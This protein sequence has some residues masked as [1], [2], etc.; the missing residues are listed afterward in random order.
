MAPQIA[1]E[2]LNKKESPVGQQAELIATPFGNLTRPEIREWERMLGRKL[3]RAG[4]T[5][6]R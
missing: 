2:R 6:G 4:I 5:M 1:A 3:L